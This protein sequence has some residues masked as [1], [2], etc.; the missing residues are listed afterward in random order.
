MVKVRPNLKQIL[1][2]NVAA[3]MKHHQQDP[4]AAAKHLK[5]H[6]YQLK[7]ILAAEHYPRVDTIQ[8]IADRYNVE[9]YQL[10]VLNLDPSNLPVVR[11][12]SP[13]DERLYKALDEARKAPPR[14]TH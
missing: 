6:P 5:M 11:L 3:L 14:G 7:R 4:A 1:A 10:L 13:E 8:R 2:S 12:F 9:P